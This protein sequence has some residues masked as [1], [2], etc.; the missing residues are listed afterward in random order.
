MLQ[1]C[2]LKDVTGNGLKPLKNYRH[3]ACWDQ[4]HGRINR[5]M[6]QV[7]SR[8]ATVVSQLQSRDATVVSQ[9]QQDSIIENLRSSFC[10][11]GRRPCGQ[12]VQLVPLC[13]LA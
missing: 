2:K 4:V 8:D 5:D 11:A 3:D 7:Q 6:H 9:L 12:T 1:V 13:A 10:Y